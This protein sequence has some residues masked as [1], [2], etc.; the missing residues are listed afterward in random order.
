MANLITITGPFD[1]MKTD[2][3]KTF[4]GDLVSGLFWTPEKP[5]FTT[6][7]FTD[8]T[9]WD[10]QANETKTPTV[11]NTIAGVI[12]S[13]AVNKKL[14]FPSSVGLKYIGTNVAAR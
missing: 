11:L 6:M 4:N 2:S 10:F 3:T 1:G 12:T 7:E 8:G 9:S 14:T 5:A 13:P